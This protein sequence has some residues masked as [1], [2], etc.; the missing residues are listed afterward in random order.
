MKA[1]VIFTTVFILLIYILPLLPHPEKIVSFPVFSLVLVA[2]I[3]WGTQPPVTIKDG[4]EN[5]GTDRSSIWLI[6]ISVVIIQLMV[7]LEWAYFRE[8]FTAFR[9]DSFTVIG[10][11]L[12]FGGTVFRVWC[13]QTL[14]KHFTV[15][16][17]T[18]SEQ[19]LIKEGPYRLIRH[20]SYLGAYLAIVGSAVLLHAYFSILFAA[21]V[22][23]LTYAY[24]I[25]VEESA[26]VEHFGDAY[27]E[28]RQETKKLIPFVY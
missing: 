20:P 14:G 27:R 17:E 7:V 26:L 15:A 22:M 25:Y 18:K 13:I 8:N 24:R 2:I 5:E 9:W 6:L 10:M 19:Q 11:I 16:V 12:L 23:F 21:V 4:Q 28:Y 3:L 1:K